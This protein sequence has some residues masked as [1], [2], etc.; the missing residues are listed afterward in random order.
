MSEH[1]SKSLDSAI[2]SKF[3]G[4]TNE[5]LIRRM[6]CADDFSYDDEEYELNR[7]LGARGLS[8]AW[9]NDRVA[10]IEREGVVGE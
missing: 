1:N 3:R 4:T 6:E 8:W 2:E 7:R 9:Q 5:E 10:I